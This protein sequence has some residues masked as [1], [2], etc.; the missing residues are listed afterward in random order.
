ML[1]T[2]IRA[3]QVLDLFSDKLPEWG[4]TAVA[5]ELGT[6][7]SQAHQLLV[8]LTD[9]GLLQLGAP[10]RYRLGW[11][12]GVLNALLLSTNEVATEAARIAAALVARYGE[13]LQLTVWASGEARCVGVWE[14][15]H[16]A[17]PLAIG[18]V[19]PGHSTA[20]GKVLLASRPW[21]EV[22]E[23]LAGQGLPGLTERTIATSETVS[24][25]L[26]AVRR[27]GFAH[28]DEEHTPGICGVAAPIRSAEGD[29]VAALSMSVPAHRWAH[30][31]G[32]HTRA[33][34]G[35]AAAATRAIRDRADRLASVE[36]G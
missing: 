14:G 26:A 19:L 33:L 27:R 3:G 16:H 5:K 6:A 7:K 13:T 18:A 4:A 2:I 17:S 23:V 8:S 30:G 35:A 32:E 21:A 28:E 1:Q 31:A 25:E 10:G 15:A 29:V 11:R 36:V 12:I 22:H 20:A 24:N 9:I 34:V